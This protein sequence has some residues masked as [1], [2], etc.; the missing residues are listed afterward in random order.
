M[1]RRWGPGPVYVYESILGARRWQV[2][3]SRSFF[4]AMLLVGMTVVW[5]ASDS[6]AIVGPAAGPL[7]FRQ[8]AEVGK[9]FFFALAGIQ[10]SLVMLAAPAA[11][12]G[13][14]CTDRLRGTLLHMMVTDLSDAE[15]VLGKL[16]AR[17][18]P[19]LGLIACAVPVTALA[20]LLG[21]IEFEALLGLFAVSAALAVL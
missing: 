15:I 17:L 12:A 13:S 4:V 11:A 16:G 20:A 1:P 8:M 7:T 2:Y 10:L 14:I 5:L 9:Q 18:G 3:A 21:G 6:P 19:V